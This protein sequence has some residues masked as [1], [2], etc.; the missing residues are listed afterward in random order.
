M[1]EAIAWEYRS[2]R[3][4]RVGDV[5]EFLHRCLREGWKLWSIEGK[6]LRLRRKGGA[7]RAA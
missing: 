7:E 2:E 1:S 4:D 3:L 5:R 6:V